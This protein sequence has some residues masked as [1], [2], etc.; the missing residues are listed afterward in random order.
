MAQPNAGLPVV[1]NLRA[2]YKQTP[3]EMAH[4]LPE[5]LRAGARIVGG[6]CGSTPA[7]I[8][9]LRVALDQHQG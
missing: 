6:C 5:L 8:R 9:A 7:H 3:E 1:E 4:G 2:V